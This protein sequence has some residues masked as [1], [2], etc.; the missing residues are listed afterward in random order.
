MKTIGIVRGTFKLIHSGH[1]RLLQQAGKI[2]DHLYVFVDSDLRLKELGKKSFILENERVEILKSIKYVTDVFSF[3]TEEEFQEKVRYLIGKFSGSVDAFIYFKG[4]DYKPQEL[5]EYPFL[6]NVGVV[7]C[8]IA[9]T[10]QS[11]TAI[12]EAIRKGEQDE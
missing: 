4:G 10:G 6:N 2:T 3:S 12:V 1:V 9:H 7:V 11:T 8:T 5:P